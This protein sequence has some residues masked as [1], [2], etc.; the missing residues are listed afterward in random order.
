[1]NDEMKKKARESGYPIELLEE[2]GQFKLEQYEYIPE[3]TKEKTLKVRFPFTANDKR[4][5]K[6]GF[7][8]Q[9]GSLPSVKDDALIP[10][11]KTNEFIDNLIDIW[12]H[13]FYII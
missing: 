7:T 3:T 9:T 8:A 5:K 10:Q 6:Y 1:M 4:C 2:M 11:T 13:L 12:K